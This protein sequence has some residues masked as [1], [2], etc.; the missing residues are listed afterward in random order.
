VILAAGKA[1]WYLS[2]GSGAVTLVLLTISFALGIPTLLS[3]G[4]PRVPRL[5]VQLMHRNVSLMVLVFLGIH[6]VTTV[7][8]SFTSIGIVDAFIPFGSTYRPIWL[9]LGALAFDILIAVIVTSVLRTSISFRMWKWVHFSSYAC[10]PIAVVHGLG[11]GTDTRFGWMQVLVVVCSVVVIAT[12]AW[13]LAV[14][15]NVDRRRN[16]AVIAGVV[17]VP[18]AIL[19]WT[20]AGPLRADWGKTHKAVQAPAPAGAQDTTETTIP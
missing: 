11:T 1:L 14:R 7:M 6:I 20:F 12:I 9:G 5:V 18:M 4:T 16:L 8:D 10:W 17:A 2:R 15:P 13:R 19:L 3:W